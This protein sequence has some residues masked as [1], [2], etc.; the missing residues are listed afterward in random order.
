MTF[1]TNVAGLIPGMQSL[2]VVGKSMEFIPKEGKKGKKVSSKKMIKG[3]T[4]IMV[5]TAMI[6]PTANIVSK[7]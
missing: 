2:A 6:Q 5:G 3:F 7:L 1:T 4:E